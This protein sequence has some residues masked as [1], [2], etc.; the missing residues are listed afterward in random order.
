MM[1]QRSLKMKKIQRYNTRGDESTTANVQLSTD[2]PP[3]IE[4]TSGVD[5]SPILKHSHPNTN[6]HS[7]NL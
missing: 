4:A 3:E 5:E 2:I 1:Q 6:N 7:K